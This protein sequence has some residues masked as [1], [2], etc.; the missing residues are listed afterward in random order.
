MFLKLLQIRNFR[1]IRQ[2]DLSFKQGLNILIGENNSGKSAVIDALRICLGYGSLNREISVRR[3]D[4]YIDR[5]NPD[6]AV[7]RIE[8]HLS[9][10]IERP[11]EAGVFYEL[12]VQKED[13][14][15]L[16]MHF[17]YFLEEKKGI[18]KIR[19]RVW[20]GEN[21]GQQVTP[22]IL[23]MFYYVYLA[24]LRDAER[25]LRPGRGN[26]LGELYATLMRDANGKII[27]DSER[28]RMAGELKDLLNGD[29]DWKNLIRGGKEKIEEHLVHTMIPGKEQEI[30]I[31]FLPFE[32][33]K[34]VDNLRIQFPVYMG[35]VIGEDSGKQRYLDVFQN[36]LGYN[37]LIYAA[38]ILGDLKNRREVDPDSF[39]A[40]LLEEPEAHLHPQLQNIFFNY[41]SELQSGFQVFVTSHSPTLTAK[42]K[43]DDTIVLY[44]QDQQ[45]RALSLAQSNLTDDN[46]RYLSKFLDVTKSQL[47]FAN[48]VVLVEGIS[49]ALLLPVFSRMIGSTEQEYDLNKHGVEIV[50]VGG[51]A[52]EHFARL[53]NGEDD[54]TRLN[55]PCAIVTDNDRSAES[56]EISLR[57]AKAKALETGLVKVELAERTFEYELFIAGEE[58]REVLMETFRDMYPRAVATIDEG[59]SIPEFA[60]N[61][62]D[63]VRDNKAKSELAHRLAVRLEGDPESRKTFVVPEYIARAIR[64]V[65]KQQTEEPYV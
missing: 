49:E 39:M 7:P 26:R 15:E 21:E 25:F 59:D 55:I 30:H 47:F 35:A 36:G 53:F 60:R 50:N 13:C 45:I 17:K 33:R 27:D 54:T 8:F 38:T 48:G 58:N 24:P 43:L 42:A 10:Y 62:V 4:F 51:V 9:F 1:G 12:L 18:E 14:L 37:N 56:G 57:A 23:G 28:A 19:W 11:E 2:L 31:D 64:W 63:K 6:Q 34:I 22:E 3:S 44:L 41:L 52:F 29:Q 5:E 65:V 61:F 40:L 46:K 20:G 32:F 16:Q